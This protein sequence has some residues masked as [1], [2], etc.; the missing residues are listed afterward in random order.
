MLTVEFKCGSMKSALL[1][2]YMP[3]QYYYSICS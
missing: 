1:W 3:N 2:W